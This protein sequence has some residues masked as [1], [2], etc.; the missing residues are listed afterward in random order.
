MPLEQRMN[1]RV[2]TKDGA[3]VYDWVA[4]QSF[5]NATQ[6]LD[7]FHILK[8]A[9]NALQY[10]RIQ[11]KTDHIIQQREREKLQI[12]YSIDSKS[13]KKNKTKIRLK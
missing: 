5:P 11:L 1:V 6:I 3:D 12:Q 10:M 2:V 4:R 8:W 7:K 9:F 13:P